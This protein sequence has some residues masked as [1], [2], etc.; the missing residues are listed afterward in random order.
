MSFKTEIYNLT[1]S[2]LLLN[3]QL[4]DVETDEDR[5]HVQV[6]NTFWNI[7]LSSTLQDLDLDMTSQ[8]ISLELLVELTE[9]PWKYAY[10]YPSNCAFLRRLES[11]TIV[12]RR[13]THISKRTG[14]YNGQTAIYTN[15]YAAIGECIPKDVSLD[16]LNAM[17]QMALAYRL[18]FLAAP[19]IT[20]KGAKKLKETL[21]QDYV[22][23]KM[24]AQET[25]ALENFNYASDIERSE[26]VEAR[27]S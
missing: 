23:A 25:D 3:E 13:S 12:D 4:V 7:A 20:G 1:L 27:Y 17:A 8:P 10:K 6:L 15:E 18:A 19:L 9:G 14:Q 5:N 16:S 26:Y 11:G 21:K 2:A 24:E 22:I